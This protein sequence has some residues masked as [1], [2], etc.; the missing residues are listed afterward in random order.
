MRKFKIIK[1][2]HFEFKI[3]PYNLKYMKPKY[4]ERECLSKNKTY[5]L[6]L[7]IPT[8]IKFKN[9]FLVKK[10]RYLNFGEI[11]LLN[12]KCNFIIN[13]NT[14]LIN[15]GI[16][17]DKNK[18]EESVV[19]TII[20]SQGSWITLKLDIYLKKEGCMF[21]KIDKMKNKIPIII[22]LQAMGLTK[23]KIIDSSPHNEILLIRS[24]NNIVS[25]TVKQALKKIN[26]INIEQEPNLYTFKYDLGEIGRIRINRKLY[27]RELWKNERILKPEDILGAVNNLIKIKRIRCVGELL[28]NHLKTSIYEIG[29][30]IKE[31]LKIVESKREKNRR[32]ETNIYINI[33]EII[34]KYILTNLLKKF[35]TTNELSQLI[36]ETN[37]LSEITHKRKISSFGTGAIDKKKANLNV[38]EIHPSQYGRICPIET[39][40]GKN[41]GLILSFSR[42]SRLNKQGFIETPF[43]MYLLAEQEKQLYLAPGNLKIKNLR[44]TNL[45]NILIRKDQEFITSKII[46]VNYINIS[47]GQMISVGTG[48][49]PFL[50]HN[51]ANRA[52][53]GSNMQRQALPLIHKETPLVETGLEK[54]IPRECGSTKISKLSG[55]IKYVSRKKIILQ[56]KIKKTNLTLLKTKTLLNKIKRKIQENYQPKTYKKTTYTLEKIK[57][58][59]QDTYYLQEP[60]VKKRKWIK[61]GETLADSPGTKNGK[62]CL[63]K[64]LLIGYMAW[65]GYNFEDAIVINEKIIEKDIFTSTH[66]K[67]Y[68]KSITRKIPYLEFENVKLLKKNGIAKEGCFINKGN[69]LVG[70]IRRKKYKTPKEKLIS[71]IFGK[72]IIKDTSLRIAKNSSGTI[73]KT[74]IL[75]K[76]SICTITI[77]ISEKRKI[78]LG[79]KIAGRHGNKGIISKILAEEDMPF[80]QDGTPLDII[81]LNP[82]GIP[83][84]MNVGQIFEC[85][86][87]LAANN[88]KETYKIQLFDEQQEDE[89]SKKTVYNKL[90]ETRKK[91][92]KKW[93]FNTNYPGKT[94]I[95]DGKTGKNFTQPITIGYAYMLKLMHLVEDKINAR[96]IGPYSSIIKQPIRG[97]AKNGGQ[98]FGEMEVWAI[99]GFGAAYT[100]QELLTIKSDDITNRSKALLAIIKGSNIPKPAIPESFKTLLI[101]LQCLCLDLSIYNKDKKKFFIN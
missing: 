80:L 53:M 14:R 91:S 64:N 78:Q 67:K 21:A 75:K 79:D 3:D 12:N 101:E 96:L 66:I 34:N 10:E 25:N 5:N 62:L 81:L 95:I 46:K 44:I 69:I 83:S 52:L 29:K 40:E 86:L 18:K 88:L 19:C 45:A 47:N 63:G 26:E 85:L 43:F 76:R 58:T 36:E 37:P 41:A 16:Y 97:K 99:E 27:K 22:L 8:T 60:I 72:P 55:V 23:K 100:L 11:P 9:K 68:K 6:S 30:D 87:G 73:I 33:N 17:F 35:F 48:L 51:D 61:R 42:E 74:K 28:Q 24:K 94:K 38:R 89:I 90:I 1:Y 65:E 70:K 93:I 56:E 82:L 84:R 92:K 57:K 50:E 71:T 13:G 4:S 49:I 2:S 32:N 54:L 39:T 15:P 59:N 7:Y 77:Y 20:P 31:K 98:R